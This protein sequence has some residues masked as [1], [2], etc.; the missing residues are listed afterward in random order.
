MSCIAGAACLMARKGLEVVD[1]LLVW[2]HLS[3]LERQRGCGGKG[4]DYPNVFVRMHCMNS[5]AS[6]S[7]KIL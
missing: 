1:F 6:I 2:G 3:L 7:L 5:S 4:E